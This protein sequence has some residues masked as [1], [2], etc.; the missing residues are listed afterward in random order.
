MIKAKSQARKFLFL[1]IA[2]SVSAPA[3]GAAFDGHPHGLKGVLSPNRSAFTLLWEPVAQAVGYNIYRRSSLKGDPVKVNAYLSS[4]T[5]FADRVDGRTYYYSVAAVDASG[6]ESAPSFLVDSSPDTRVIYL[7]PDG[8]TCVILPQNAADM[9]RPAHNPYGV[10]LT[11]Q[12]KEEDIAQNRDIVRE[13]RLQLVRTDTGEEIKD[14]AF[15]A[16]GALVYVGY[17]MVNG[18]LARG[19][20]RAAGSEHA[21]V[22]GAAPE[23]LVL[24][25]NN[26]VSWIELGG[27]N[28][29][30][31][32]TVNT[33]SPVLGH[34]Q[35]RT[36]SKASALSLE[37]SN[38]FP[39]LFTP[40]GDGFNDQVYFVLDNPN[41]AAVTGEIFDLMGRHIATL[42]A[43]SQP[44]G[45][46]T[47]L[48]WIG[49]DS[50]GSSV[51]S[52]LYVYR[53][54]GDGTTL[55]GTIAVGR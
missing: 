1:A 18:Q 55:T 32:Q 40:N 26:G 43:P 44:L 48:T 4:L 47:T 12:L 19:A 36:A 38:V 28:D 21:L 46:A 22:S 3:L 15:P 34:Y 7:A 30:N 52:G 11:I 54:K 45:P 31:A 50:Q 42:P 33:V 53:I 13:V 39:S 51:P 29:R 5:V 35:L 9:L 49:L 23:A 2:I 27:I 41:G 8:V 24:Y 37:K 6:A 25:W 16:P 14:V 10:A 17:H 20:P